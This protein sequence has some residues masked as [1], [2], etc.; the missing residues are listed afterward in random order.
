MSFHDSSATYAAA[1]PAEQTEGPDGLFE[2]GLICSAG[3]S[4]AVDLIAAHKWF[5]LAALRGRPDAI[6]LRREIA[7]QMSE[8]EIATAQREA[9]AWISLH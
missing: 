9:R 6:V 7:E 8:T 1:G 4:G 3:L 2:L 5:N